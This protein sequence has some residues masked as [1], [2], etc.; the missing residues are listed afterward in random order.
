MDE[1]GG[2]PAVGRLPR[3]RVGGPHPVPDLHLGDRLDGAIR[4][5]HQRLADEA[6]ARLHRRPHRVRREPGTLEDLA[7][8]QDAGHLDGAAAHARA[9]P[10]ARGRIED[11][12]DPFGQRFDPSDAASVPGPAQWGD[13][14]VNPV[15]RKSGRRL[16][17]QRPRSWSDAIRERTDLNQAGAVA[18]RPMITVSA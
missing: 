5:Q 8:R 12:L 17:T 11:Q 18:L 14:L 6:V 10:H 1:G 16:M 15:V 13:Q 4:H 3:L 2:D 9:G 7:H